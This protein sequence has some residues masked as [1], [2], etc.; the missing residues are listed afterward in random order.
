MVIHLKGQRTPS[1][2]VVEKQSPD[3]NDLIYLNLEKDV[4]VRVNTQYLS[5]FGKR[6]K[7]KFMDSNK[8]RAEDSKN[9]IIHAGNTIGC[10]RQAMLSEQN[11]EYLAT[12]YNI[13]DY[14]DF[15]DG[16]GSESA[17]VSILDHDKDPDKL[18]DYQ[19]DVKFDDFTAHP[20]Y[21]DDDGVVL[22]LK[23]SKKIKPFILSE[24]TV[25]K[26][27]R[28]LTLYLILTD[29]TEGI[30]LARYARPDFLEYIRTKKWDPNTGE[31]DYSAMD[32]IMKLNEGL[33]KN[34]TKEDN[35]YKVVFHRDSGQFPFWAVS[36][37]IEADAKSR[38]IVKKAMREVTAPL[39]KAGDVTQIPILD[40]KETNWAC[41]KYCKVKELC[42]QTPDLQT[43]PN[44]R[45]VLLNKHI[46]QAINKEVSRERRNKPV[47]ID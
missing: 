28:Q 40:D 14:V 32:E 26:Y 46:D 16:N 41:Q 33:N 3:K 7:K 15:M 21:I 25:K 12:K 19:L 9:G 27:I 35:L 5:K 34:F 23:S 29:K 4:K 39:Y 38:E 6:V 47:D 2:Q 42:D 22:E 30:I 20:D 45:F 36:V 43:D 1:Q 11:L 8:K 44:K 24:E 17:I 13:W 31:Y 10:M 18:G 37:E